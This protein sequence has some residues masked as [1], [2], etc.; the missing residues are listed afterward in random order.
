MLNIDKEK[1]LAAMFH[2]EEELTLGYR[3]SSVFFEYRL[4]D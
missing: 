1:C 4:E 2:K 3:V